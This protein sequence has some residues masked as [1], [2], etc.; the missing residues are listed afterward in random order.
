[1]L[2][3]INY[4]LIVIL[5]VSCGSSKRVS[6]SQPTIRK[7]VDKRTPNQQSS[8]V[9]RETKVSNTDPTIADKVI[10]TAVT[11]KGTP[12]R[13]GGTTKSGMDCSGLVYTS[14]KARGIDL[15]RSSRMMHTE[16]Y[17]ISLSKAKRGDLLFFKTG[18]SGKVN[19]VGLV[20]SSDNGNVKFIHSTSSKGV[21][22]SSVLEKYWKKAFF[23]VK[24]II[25]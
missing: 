11:Y 4:L 15:P 12:Y 10:W 9:V 22:V 25:E 24:R 23:E 14:F 2:K 1:M 17:K 18:R 3:K 20:T 5:I 7:V 8:R 13:S 6:R 19:H 16:G 21:I